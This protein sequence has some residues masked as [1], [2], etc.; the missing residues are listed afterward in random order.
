MSILVKMALSTAI[1]W[2][3]SYAR[4]CDIPV[5]IDNRD[6]SFMS[7]SSVQCGLS[8]INRFLRLA[9]AALCLLAGVVG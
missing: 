4:A 1:D 2:K 8:F 6:V 3:S 9:L 5:P 7:A